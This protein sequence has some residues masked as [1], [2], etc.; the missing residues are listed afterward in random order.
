MKIDKAALAIGVCLVLGATGS[1]F[2]GS[3]SLPTGDIVLA[4]AEPATPGVATGES[5]APLSFAA[6][7]R[8]ARQRAQ[9]RPV[10]TAHYIR[11]CGMCQ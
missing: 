9:E 5:G 3:A 7:A 6:M 4:A 1:A 11:H 10:Q 8:Q 2:A